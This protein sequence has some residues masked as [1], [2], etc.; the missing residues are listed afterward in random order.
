MNSQTSME[1][2]N[3]IDDI[4][5]VTGGKFKNWLPD[6]IEANPEKINLNPLREFRDSIYTA[7]RYYNQA[8]YYAYD[9]MMDQSDMLEMEDYNGLAV[10][11]ALMALEERKKLEEQAIELVKPVLNF[12]TDTNNRYGWNKETSNMVLKGIKDHNKFGFSVFAAKT[13]FSLTKPINPNVMKVQYKL[14]HIKEEIIGLR[15]KYLIKYLDSMG[16]EEAYNL[17]CERIMKDVQTEE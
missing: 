15:K 8:I 11:Y 16:F 14:E 6:I 13:Y 3:L 2:K 5:L 10:E 4:V 12:D 7:V 9:A 1:L 17:I